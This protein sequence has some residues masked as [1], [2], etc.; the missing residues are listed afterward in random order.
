MIGTKGVFMLISS[1]YRLILVLILE[2]G[3][4]TRNNFRWVPFG[5]RCSGDTHNNIIGTVLYLTAIPFL[6]EPRGVCQTA[7]GAP[8]AAA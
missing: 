7:A 6:L 1:K 2:S 5:A 4:L 8:C 3:Q